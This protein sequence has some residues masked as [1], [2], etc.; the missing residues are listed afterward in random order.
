[1]EYQLEE[2]ESMYKPWSKPQETIPTPHV[3]ISPNLMN[4]RIVLCNAEVNLSRRLAM[5][6]RLRN[7]VERASVPYIDFMINKTKRKMEH[8]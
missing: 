2:R 7:Q 8:D 6:E 4:D 5:F 1:M 3:S